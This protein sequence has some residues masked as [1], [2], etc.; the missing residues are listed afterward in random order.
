ML[1]VNNTS[2]FFPNQTNGVVAIYTLNNSTS[3]GLQAQE[4]AY[5]LD[6]GFSFQRYAGNPVIN[7]N[8]NS[9]RDPKVIWH[10]ETQR[11]VMVV[12]HSSDVVLSIYTS[13]DLKAWTLASNF[14]GATHPS[15]A[16]YECPNLVPMPAR[17]LRTGASTPTL[18]DMYVLTVGV[19]SGGPNGGSAIA[20]FPGT[21]NGTHFTPV[22][23]DAGRFTDIAKDSYAGQ[24]WYN[25]PAGEDPLSIAW[26]SNLQYA[27]SLPTAQEGWRS[28]MSLPRRNSLVVTDSAGWRLVSY[29]ADLTPV[30]GAVLAHSENLDDGATTPLEVDYSAVES[31]AVFLTATMSADATLLFN[32]SNS[33]TGECVSGGFT[34]PG[35]FFLDRGD[36]KGF[37]DP[38][39]TANFSTSVAPLINGTQ[40][41][42]VV[43]DRS[44]I[45]VFINGGEYSGTATFFA[46]QPLNLLTLS[47]P[48]SPGD[49]LVSV[50]VHALNSTWT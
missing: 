24:F 15:G 40:R 5:S 3:P 30:L 42:A 39:F 14:T 7:V 33:L 35:E 38:N 9:F 19:S 44:I 21:F 45:E 34:T 2:G 11:W 18:D 17:D 16:G 31:N 26:A 8:S 6:G 47:T 1:D 49:A 22:D 20:Y 46:T 36:T 32:F 37:T 10:A 41:L 23:D 48:G 12:A 50:T 43:V 13:Q 28:T 27:G 29:P 25:V 4:I